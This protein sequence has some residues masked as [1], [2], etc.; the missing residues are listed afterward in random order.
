MLYLHGAGHFHPENI[1]DNAFFENLGIETNEQWILERVGI[2]QRRTVLDL[3]YIKQTHNKDHSQAEQ[4]VQYTLAQTAVPAV[5]MAL[6]R[7]GI[8][9][10][11]VGMVIASTC[12]GDH[13]VP[14]LA[15]LIAAEVGIEQTPCVDLSSACSSFATHLHFIDAMA[16][17][18][19]PDYVLLVQAENWT[20][21]TDYS[22]RRTCVLIGDATA[23]TVV[24]K[25]HRSNIRLTQTTLTSDP[26]NWN[27]VKIPAFSHFSQD[28][29]AVQKFAIKKTI[30]TFR[31]LQQSIDTPLNQHYFISHQANLT[32]LQSVCKKL[33]IPNEKHLYNV[34]KYGNCAAAGAPSVLSQNWQR[35]KAGDHLTLVVVGAGLTWGGV[36]ITF[37]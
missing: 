19:C 23:A 37:D 20:K 8:T 4:H 32:M 6:E 12:A 29:P 3:D 30:E 1:L 25:K 35:F 7:A 2:Q 34:D 36:S 10:G 33:E 28:G 22:D 16:E 5:E 31:K 15:G 14:A 17:D 11:D 27:K 24:S 26:Q 9:A 13:L 18:K 21:S